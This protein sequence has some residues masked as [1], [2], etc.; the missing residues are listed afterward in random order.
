MIPI[1]K[2]IKTPFKIKKEN[3][4]LPMPS[5]T[6]KV[7]G[8]CDYIQSSKNE[9][10][11][12]FNDGGDTE[13]GEIGTYR[14]GRIR[15]INTDKDKTQII[16]RFKKFKKLTDDENKDETL[17]RL[18]EITDFRSDKIKNAIE[19]SLLYNF[20]VSQLKKVASQK[21]LKFTQP[22]KFRRDGFGDSFFLKIDKKFYEV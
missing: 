2:D 3:I 4:L 22:K 6:F 8:R 21:N 19:R 18:V 10:I 11:Y 7:N 12:T 16:I 14:E 17:K 15:E 20:S 9:F 5:A 13:M 1:L